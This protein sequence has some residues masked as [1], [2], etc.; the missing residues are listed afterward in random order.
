MESKEKAGKGN[1]GAKQVREI[2]E[3]TLAVSSEAL[4]N[5]ALD[6][7]AA[8]KTHSAPVIDEESKLLGTVS[9]EELN[10]KVGGLGHEPKSFPVESEINKD[11]GLCFS[12]QKI[13]EAEELMRNKKV[14]EVPV[15]KRELVLIGKATLCKIEEEKNKRI[16]H[17]VA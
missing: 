12:D 9:R 1:V 13:G 14:D 6:E 2:V 15:V 8:H 7:M 17:Q 3:P 5:A 10:R 16:S 11:N 4:V